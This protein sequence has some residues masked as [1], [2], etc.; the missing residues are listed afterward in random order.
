MAPVPHCQPCGSAGDRASQQGLLG[1]LSCDALLWAL[2]VQSLPGRSSL[3]IQRHNASSET[4]Q[5]RP[6]RAQ[7]TLS[8]GSQGM[9]PEKGLV[10]AGAENRTRVRRAPGA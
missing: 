9:R 5:S 2:T 10:T 8:P 3:Y 6:S 7:S 1:A 4:E